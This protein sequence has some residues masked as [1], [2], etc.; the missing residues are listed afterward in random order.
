MLAPLLFPRWPTL[1]RNMFYYCVAGV[2][3]HVF[4]DK[5]GSSPDAVVATESAFLRSDNIFPNLY[6][7]RIK[8][9][10]RK[11]R[12]EHRS[13]VSTLRVNFLL[14]IEPDGNSEV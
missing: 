5:L 3:K 10:M 14:R 12:K 13:F 4:H 9:S 7:P 2:N 1:N 11:A 8:E 6:E